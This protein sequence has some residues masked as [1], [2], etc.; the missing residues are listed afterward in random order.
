MGCETC[1]RRGSMSCAQAGIVQVRGAG[2]ARPR[3][4]GGGRSVRGAGGGRCYLP[5]EKCAAGWGCRRPRR[6][7]RPFPGP[8]APARRARCGGG[9]WVCAV[10]RARLRGARLCASGPAGLCGSGTPRVRG[11]FCG[12]GVAEGCCSPWSIWALVWV[13]GLAVGLAAEFH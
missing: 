8:A 6:R 13:T 1:P 11:H 2:A 12:W 7:E 9:S 10:I 5:T 4:E 3:L